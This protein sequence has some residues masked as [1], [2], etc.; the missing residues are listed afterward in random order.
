[1]VIA[2]LL[3]IPFLLCAFSS[4]HA[5]KKCFNYLT[6]KITVNHRINLRLP[7]FQG[8]PFSSLLFGVLLRSLRH[9]K[10]HMHSANLQ[11][12]RFKAF[13]CISK[14]KQSNQMR[15]FPISKVHWPFI[16]VHW[17]T[18]RTGTGKSGTLKRATLTVQLPGNTAQRC[19]H[20]K[21]I[22]SNKSSGA[23]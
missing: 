23:L 2:G 15:A 3:T 21:L 1:M 10:T 14:A 5:D 6:H 18:E 20:Q 16:A 17:R 22:T 19:S 9:F 4:K 7:H 11:K 13:T 12:A 8:L